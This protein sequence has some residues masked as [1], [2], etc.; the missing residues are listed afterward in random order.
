MEVGEI[1]VPSPINVK[2]SVSRSGTLRGLHYQLEPFAQ[3]KIIRVCNGKILDVAVNLNSGDLY[4]I[5]L[6]ASDRAALYVPVGFA[7]GFQAI[8]DNSM[9]VY[10]SSNRHAPEHERA[11][12]PYIQHFDSFS[13]EADDAGLVVSDKDKSAPAFQF[14]VQSRHFRHIGD[15]WI[16]VTGR[17]RA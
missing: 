8:D 6:A 2:A 13:W 15:E 17:G 1:D 7:H 12:C 16:D 3:A 10:A 4:E 9:I 5:T 11:F 14:S